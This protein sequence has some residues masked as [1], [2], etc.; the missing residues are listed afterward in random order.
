MVGYLLDTNV[1]S[2]LQKPRPHPQVLAWYEGIA[3]DNLYLSAI[4]LG[5]IRSGIEQAR[6]TKPERAETLEHWLQGLERF[7]GSRILPFSAGIADVW[8]RM[9][10]HGNHHLIDAQLA[11][12][13]LYHRFVLVTRNIKD[14]QGRGVE[15]LNPWQF[16]M[17]A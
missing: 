3:E 7:Y 9:V 16:Q 10:A 8:G 14:V 17:S 6:P 2:E 12:T 1:I 4:T 15:T 13:A 11:A 5:E